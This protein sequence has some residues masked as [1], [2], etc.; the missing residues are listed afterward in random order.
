VKNHL[1]YRLASCKKL[2]TLRLK[3]DGEKRQPIDDSMKIL[4]DSKIFKVI[5][6]ENFH[7]SLK[8]MSKLVKNSRKIQEIS[9]R[10]CNLPDEFFSIFESFKPDLTKLE[11]SYNADCNLTQ[12]PNGIFTLSSLKYLDL[13]CNNFVDFPSEIKLLKDLEYLDLNG[14]KIKEIGDEIGSLKKL[15]FLNLSNNNLETISPK[16]GDLKLLNYLM[17]DENPN[18]V[19]FPKELY[20]FPNLKFLSVKNTPMEKKMKPINKT[21][22]VKNEKCLVQ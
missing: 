17:L 15:S 8:S 6:L 22:T 5:S 10:K 16:I 19:N 13:S 12:I 21:T 9:L 7:I 11:I 2:T 3:H 14:N 4:S 20:S 1:N 18:I